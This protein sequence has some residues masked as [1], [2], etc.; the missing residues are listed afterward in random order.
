M[1]LF[2]LFDG[3]LSVLVVCPIWFA[4]DES[5]DPRWPI[6]VLTEGVVAE[7]A[8][9]PGCCAELWLWAIAP[10]VNAIKPAA[11]AAATLVSMDSFI[12]FRL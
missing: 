12:I 5:L 10:A 3:A 7:G 4:L 11:T 9:G 2:G 1:I 6:C 8:Y